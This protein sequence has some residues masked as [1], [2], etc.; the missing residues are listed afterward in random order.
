IIPSFD[1][2]SN[3][4]YIFKTP[5]QKR[6]RRDY[7]EPMWKVAMATSAAPTFFPCFKEVE[8]VRLIDGGIWANNP[9]M[10]GIIE[11]KSML[12]IPLENIWVCSLGTTDELNNRPKSLNHGGYLQWW[13]AAIDI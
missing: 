4:V 5:H 1:I 2:D 7:K 12:D 11:A 9:T 10:V 6:L 3:S 13:K 8:N